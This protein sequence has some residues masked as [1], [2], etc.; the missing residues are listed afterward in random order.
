MVLDKVTELENRKINIAICLSGEPRYWTYG[1]AALCDFVD[2]HQEDCNIHVFYHFWN[3][4][5]KRQRHLLKDPIIET[6]DSNELQDHYNPTIGICESKDALNSHI[7]KAWE[8]V[9]E[10][11]EKHNIS[12]KRCIKSLLR[13][14]PEDLKKTGLDLKTAFYTQIKTTNSPPFSQMI[15]MCKSLVLMLDYAEENNIYYDIIIR[16]RSDVEIKPISEKKIRSFVKKDHLSRY[17]K[18]PAMSTRTP[19][20]MAPDAH[21]PYVAYEFFL[22]SSTTIIKS[23]FKNYSKRLAK[24]L[25]DVKNPKDECGNFIY[26]SS[27]N[28]VPLFFKNETTDI[29]NASGRLLLGSPCTPFSYRLVRPNVYDTTSDRLWED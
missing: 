3:D 16:S 19:R 2:K 9:E 21:T 20:H 15:T 17:I 29:N 18:F 7:D 22:G 10:M 6:I 11:V 8:H 4:I 5:T 24:L 25:I 13:C 1:A 28:C 27:H 23:M 14:Q 26:T 12:H